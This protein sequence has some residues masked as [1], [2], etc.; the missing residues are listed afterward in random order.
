MSPR[1]A[2]R[3]GRIPLGGLSADASP[4]LRTGER[5]AKRPGIQAGPWKGPQAPRVHQ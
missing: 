3:R 2:A 5:L 1:P 4:C